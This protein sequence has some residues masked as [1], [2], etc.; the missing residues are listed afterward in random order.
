MFRRRKPLKEELP[1]KVVRRA[2]MIPTPDLLDWAENALYTAHRNLSAYRARPDSPTA[3]QNFA[4][5]R[6]SVA[7]LS[8]VLAELE[9]RTGI[10]TDL[11]PAPSVPPS[12]IEQLRQEG[13]I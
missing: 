9:S 4:E 8:A 7:A 13:V 3:P 12:V 11:A 10:N 6:Q 5:A 2:R 1:E